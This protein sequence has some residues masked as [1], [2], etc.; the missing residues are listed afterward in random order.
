MRMQLKT[1]RG[2]GSLDGLRVLR[3]V[4]VS[5]VLL[6]VGGCNNTPPPA[7]SPLTVLEEDAPPAATQHS[8][9]SSS[10]AA[11]SNS[12]VKV[13]PALPKYEPAQGVSGNIKSIG[14]DTMNN[15]MALWAGGFRKFYPAVQP[16]IEGKGSS[17]APAALISGTANFGPMS[18]KMKPSEID[19]FQ[20]K[21]EYKPIELETAVDAL[22]VYVHKD[23]P[24]KGLTLPQA[25]AI[26]SGTRK[27]GLTEEV[28]T[29]DQLGLEGDFEKKPLS[30]YGRNA[31]SGTYGFFKEHALGGGDFKDS[32][33]EQP[34]SSAV[35][36]G[37]SAD[38]FGI[39]YSGIGYITSGVRA[40]PLAVAEGDDFITAEP[41]HA[42]S[43]A[44]PL[45]RTL[46]V[47][48]NYQ[49]GSELDPL[50][51]EFIKYIFSQ[52]GQQEVIKDGYFPVTAEMARKQLQ[53]VGIPADF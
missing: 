46:N 7:R 10:A 5:L 49:P 47:A 21:F 20:A 32:V 24:L 11:S 35:V 8:E 19:Q 48:V 4:A 27:L 2:A 53:A 30:L 34:G 37:V 43:G 45:S 18:R 15:L 51:K 52:E 6:I 17:T 3:G 1:C 12:V 16:E 44:Y 9:D 41:D 50:R 22:A 38:K 14:S 29:W 13:D 39:G 42:Y 26:F 23:N 31:A 25:D 33:K 36:Q 28:R 40:V